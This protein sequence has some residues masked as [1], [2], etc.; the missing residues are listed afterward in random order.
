MP[1]RLLRQHATAALLLLGAA[2][3]L[4]HGQGRA[5]TD[6]LRAL[7]RLWAQTYTKHDTAAAKSLFSDSIVITPASGRLK[8]KQGELADVRA[9]PDLRVHYFRTQ[10]VG[11]RVHG[12]TGIVT[13]LAEWEYTYRGKVQGVR[14][15]Y[16]AVY[17]RGGSLGWQM[18]ALH[19]GPA[20]DPPRTP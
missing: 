15:R 14:R 7:D 11:V 2:P 19:L 4:A 18:V 3:A 8:D 1:A 20:P 17:S 10:D 13:G 9:D 5:A 12:G 6:S 16:T